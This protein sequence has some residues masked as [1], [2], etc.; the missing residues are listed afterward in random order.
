MK[1][2]LSLR[3]QT[4]SAKALTKVEAKETFLFESRRKTSKEVHFDMLSTTV[5]FLFEVSRFVA[6]F[7][8]LLDEMTSFFVA[9]KRNSTSKMQKVF[10]SSLNE[11]VV[12]FHEKVVENVDFSLNFFD[13]SVRW[14]VF[15][16]LKKEK[17]KFFSVRDKSPFSDFES[18]FH[19]LIKTFLDLSI[20][21]FQFLDFRAQKF[22]LF[23]EFRPFRLLF[24][25]FL[26]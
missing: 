25:D 24:V 4:K 14:N 8:K 22:S 12:V 13:G 20:F 17:R 2:N 6:F 26:R 23:V 19:R 16:F 21:L 15:R 3:F 11:R 7:S 18:F 1:R 5:K 9:E 10:F